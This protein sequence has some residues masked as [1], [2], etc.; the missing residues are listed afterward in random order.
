MKFI[1]RISLFLILLHFS[2]T[3]KGQP[4]TSTI[5]GKVIDKITNVPLAG[6]N[7]V[8]PG[9]EPLK[10]TVT[11]QDGNF[12]LDNIPI[13]RTTI[14]VTYIGYHDVV[15]S[16]LNVNSARELILTIEMEESIV[17]N[18]TVVI[19]GEKDKTIPANK[20]STVSARS[21]TVEESQRY[22]GAR[23]DVARMVS[24][25]AGVTGTSDARN[26]IIIRGNSPTG[27]LWRLEGVDIPNPNHFAAFGTT[28]GPVSMLK[29]STLKNSDFLTAA[30][31][32]E[33]GNALSGVFDL[34]M[35][36]GNDEKH[37]FTGNVA[38]N[39]IGIDAEGPISRK[40]DIS[41][42]FNF[43][44]STLGF[45]S[46]FN[47]E[48]GT[49]MAVPKFQDLT[50]KVN[51]PKTKFG[52][53]SIFALGGRSY[54]A[55]INSTKDS[56][57]RKTDFYS[58][59]DRDITNRSDVGIIG[60][61][62]R[63]I[64]SKTA[65]TSFA[66]AATYH[67]YETKIDS[68]IKT[69]SLTTS[70]KLDNFYETKLFSSFYINKKLSKKNNIKAGIIFTTLFYNL[71]DSTL[72]PGLKDFE[73]E[74]DYHDYTFLLQPYAEWQF[75]I[76]DNITLNSGL[77]FMYFIYNQSKSTE[78]RIGLKWEFAKRHSVGLGYGLHSQ[79]VPI[80]VFF[81][82]EQAPGGNYYL[83]NDHL[84][85]LKSQHFVFSYDWSIRDFMRLKAEVYYQKL[86]NIPVN[87]Q[88]NDYFSIL[89]LGANFDEQSPD[90][91]SNT[92]TGENYGVEITLERFLHKGLYYL[93]TSS[94]YNSTYTGSDGI[95]R[96]TAFNGGYNLNL[97]LGKEF[98]LPHKNKAVVKREKTLYFDFK[99]NL[100]G[101][102]R[103]TPV[104]EQESILR[105]MVI[106]DNNQAYSQQFPYYSRTDLKI[107][108]K[109]NG[110]RMTVEW[111]IEITNLFNR[112]NVY[113]QGFDVKTGQPY[114][115]YQ[116][117]R[118]F[119]PQYTTTF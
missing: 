31:P 99:T 3:I 67:H 59:D 90:F 40:K 109:M 38:F 45:F 76:S 43:R 113:S 2:T 85:L 34:R 14:K 35:I 44:I 105:Q 53:F 78:P 77:H 32:A 56:N 62:H 49:G 60:I 13:G 5:R 51:M 97:L 75:R 111:G 50:F 29:S 106:Y 110:K 41:Y 68:I 101:G 16:N 42:L 80:N 28:G 119:I 46:R 19:T 82:Q 117:G 95:T 64:I 54:I 88:L 94:L 27:L 12:R 108:F 92:G 96:N 6:A 9:T 100:S 20:M 81:T 71:L 73:R 107:G 118:L 115:I 57:N 63:Y 84:D 4:I 89:N 11:D 58:S 104:N 87:S 69:S 114:Y 36:N 8:I 18:T 24:S 23:N 52:S 55:F 70:Y 22:A 21:F 39:G 61:T 37:E 83:T 102:Q 7:V 116:L 30:F 98:H 103:Y 25:F 33:Y 91:L 26:D 17:Q 48:F 112:K 1:L 47:I 72:R 10:G 79:T 15:L 86:F 93:F 66:I 74:I 65:Y